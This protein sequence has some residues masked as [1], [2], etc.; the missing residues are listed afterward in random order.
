[1]QL[2]STKVAA[3]L[4]VIGVGEGLRTSLVGAA[5]LGAALISQY[6]TVMHG[7][8]MKTLAFFGVALLLG[9]SIGGLLVRYGASQ[10]DYYSEIIGLALQR[11]ACTAKKSREPF[12]RRVG[13]SKRE[14]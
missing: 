12:R 8:T 1:L 11:K 7:W 5:M 14:N 6:E 9:M 13:L 3:R 10:A 2:E 4:G